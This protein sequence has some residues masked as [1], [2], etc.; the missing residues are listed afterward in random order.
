MT[1]KD[2]FKTENSIA[3]SYIKNYIYPSEVL[4]HIGEI[5]ME[6]G[7]TLGDDFYKKV[8]NIWIAKNAKLPEFCTINGPCIID[9]DAQIRPSAFIRGNAIIG[10]NSVVGNSCEIK[11]AIL[12]DNVEVPHFNYVG[13]SI[14]GYKSHLGAGSIISNLKSTKTNV[15][16]NGMETKLRKVGAFL[17]DYAEIGCNSVLTPGTIVGSNTII[18]PLTMVRGVIPENKI[19]KSMDN[20]VERTLK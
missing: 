14:L 19:V 11:N 13:D 1:N 4:P 7:K 12:Y 6:I 3:D 9:H 2:L 20:I 18:Y 17:G 16:I 10:K 15:T 8:D 5:I